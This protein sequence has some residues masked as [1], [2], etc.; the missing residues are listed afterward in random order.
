M[1]GVVRM[2]TFYSMW[3][4]RTIPCPK[5]SGRAACETT[6]LHFEDFGIPENLAKF[7]VRHGMAGFIQKMLPHVPVFIADR[8]SRCKPTEA[9]PQAYGQGIEPL[10]RAGSG[11][12]ASTPESTPGKKRVT[13]DSD[14]SSSETASTSY[15][16]LRRSS[17][18]R[19]FG[20][21]LLASGVAIAL[22]R[23]GSASSL[24]GMDREEDG[25]DGEDAH[26]VK[27]R[28]G[29]AHPGGPQHSHRHASRR[30]PHMRAVGALQSHRITVP[31]DKDHS[32]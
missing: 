22:S 32:S 28:H 21:L 27:R 12:S 23:A 30:R 1:P 25:G 19:G 18:I 20:Y 31:L 26:D 2:S 11:C 6:L 7:T 9:D 5:G 14:D 13:I 24:H 15:K 29:R 16:T 4:S 8:R 17:S 3:C 10:L